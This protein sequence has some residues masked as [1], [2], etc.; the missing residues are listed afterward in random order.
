M[1]V[2]FRIKTEVRIEMGFSE[3]GLTISPSLSI[4]RTSPRYPI[5][6]PEGT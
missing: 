5:K 1:E 3:T 4:P 6:S 2:M